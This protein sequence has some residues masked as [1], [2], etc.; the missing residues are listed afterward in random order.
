[1]LDRK[2]F[3]V[4]KVL[5][6]VCDEGTYKVVDY[7]S[8][9]QKVSDQKHSTRLGL[10]Q[11]LAHLKTGQYIDIKYSENNTYCL[12]VLPKGRMMVEENINSLKS[13]RRAQFMMCLTI[14]LSGIMSFLGAFV[15]V[16]LLK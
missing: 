2:S 1:M 11:I 3:K 14:A 16:C 12:S 9:M 4:L 10:E 8:L 15:A 5:N 7:D 6:S 13:Q